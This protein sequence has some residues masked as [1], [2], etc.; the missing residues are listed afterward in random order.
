MPRQV[1]NTTVVLAEGPTET[2]LDVEPAIISE[3]YQDDTIPI[4]QRVS[5]RPSLLASY[6]GR[7][8]LVATASTFPITC[9]D[10]YREALRSGALSSLAWTL[11]RKRG[12]HISLDEARRVAMR[13]M[14]EAEQRL[15]QDR[16]EE[17]QFI[18]SFLEEGSEV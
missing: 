10:P 16:A 1:Y 6:V 3:A 18:L 14:E 8:L 13:I 2:S 4:T 15:R 7:F 9:Y 17:V 5:R 12:R 11:P